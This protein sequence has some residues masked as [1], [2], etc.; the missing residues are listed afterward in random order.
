MTASALLTTHLGA[1]RRAASEGPVLDLACGTGRNGLYLLQENI[2]VVFADRDP[3]ALQ[4]VRTSLETPLC[5]DC[6]KLAS[7]WRVDFE[8]AQ[9]SPLAASAYGAILVF[10]YLHRPLLPDIRNAISPGGLLVYETFTVDQVAFGRPKNPDFLLRA[11]ELLDCFGGW[12]V[13]HSFEGIVESET[14][15]AKQA[16]AQIVAVKPTDHSQTD[17]TG[18]NHGPAL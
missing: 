2:P 14:G 17:N 15:A 7:L 3:T 9:D 16:I 10:R 12:T 6:R 8:L 1:I 18:F 5:R 13:L 4:Q 11:N